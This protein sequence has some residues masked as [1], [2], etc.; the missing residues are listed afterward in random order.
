MSN[1]RRSPRWTR[2]MAIC[3][4][5]GA[6]SR[7]NTARAALAIGV[8]AALNLLTLGAYAQP[9]QALIVDS[10]PLGTTDLDG[11]PQGISI[12]LLELL[13]REIGRDIEPLILPR[14]GVLSRVETQQFDLVLLYE[15]AFSEDRLTYLGRL[16]DISH[17]QIMLADT[18]P[19]SATR[20]GHLSQ[21]APPP[22]AAE[23]EQRLPLQSFQTLEEAYDA[24]TTGL[25]QGILLPQPSARVVLNEPPFDSGL[26]FKSH[27][28][29]SWPVG[30]Y[31]RT[32][33]LTAE[34][35]AAAR[36]TMEIVREEH[37]LDSFLERFYQA[38]ASNGARSGHF[39]AQ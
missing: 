36:R 4:H 39:V 2:Y 31:A 28:L 12:D 10:A 33:A 15:D 20:I 26:A 11:Q 17:V 23:S 14:E 29:A 38:Q 37:M 18:D 1:S 21:M 5:I 24:L 8:A 16:D 25:V 3:Q 6:E 22:S 32:G 35:A 34:E 30:L 19:S 7:P 9:L 27:A 13:A